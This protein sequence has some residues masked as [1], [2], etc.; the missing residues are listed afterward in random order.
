MTFD[1]LGPVSKL[2]MYN[3]IQTMIME[4]FTN[5]FKRHFI[6]PNPMYIQILSILINKL[7]QYPKQDR[8][9]QY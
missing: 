2:N 6:S 5:F 1:V 4:Q 9:L 8:G 7:R 3:C